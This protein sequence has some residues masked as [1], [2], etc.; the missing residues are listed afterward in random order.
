M[1]NKSLIALQKSKIGNKKPT[2]RQVI[3]KFFRI[4]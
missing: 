1:S 3:Y 4:K 2:E